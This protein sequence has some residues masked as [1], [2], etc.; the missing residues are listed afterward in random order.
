[1]IGHNKQLTYF[2]NVIKN[3]LLAHAYLFSGPE[4]IGKKLF[5]L[6]LCRIINDRLPE[7]DLDIKVFSPK[8]DEDKMKI[9]I[10]NIKELRKFLS[11]K[12]QTG[13]Y[14]FV[15]LDDAHC[16]TNEA[17]NALLK[18]LEE[19]PMFSIIILIS[20]LPGLLPATIVSRCEEVRFREAIEK[21][22]MNFLNDRILDS[23][24]KLTKDNKDFLLKLSGGRIGLINRLIQNNEIE[25]ARKNVDE[26][27]KLLN[28]GICEKLD[29][30]KKIYDTNNYKSIVDYWLSW[31]SS[32]IRKSSK[33]EKIVKELLFLHQII[34]QPQY[35]HRLALENFLLN[36]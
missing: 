15:I 4:M 2:Q 24:M 6:N 17:S 28:A 32:Y 34:S 8:F 9:Y 7:S 3:G 10:E 26:L 27:R 30:A 20:F 19:P 14:K 21:E 1:M 16:L 31:V 22:V 13:L 33:N 11:Y 35:N 23:H 25:V 12:S 5:A 18:I 29:Y 36:L